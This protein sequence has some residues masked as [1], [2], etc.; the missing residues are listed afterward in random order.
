MDP[1]RVMVIGHGFSGHRFAKVIRYIENTRPELARLVAICDSN[2][3]RLRET[4]GVPC[5]AR[6]E[7]ALLE[8]EPTVAVV[9]VNESAHYDVLTYLAAGP[10]QRRLIIAEKPLTETFEQA[11]TLRSALAG[12]SVAVNFIERYSPIVQVF[13]QWWAEHAELRPTRVEFFWGKDRIRDPRPTIGV[14]SEITHPLD[15]VAYLFGLRDPRIAAVQATESDFSRFEPRCLDTVDAWIDTADFRLIGH[16]SFCWSNRLRRIFAILSDARGQG[17]IV[18]FDFDM[19]RWDC[20]RLTIRVCGEKST[21]FEY[22]V[23]NSFFPRQLDELGKVS[24]FTTR[25]IESFRSGTMHEQ[26]VGLEMAVENQRLTT[27][28]EDAIAA[29]GGARRMPMFG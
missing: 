28:I 9:A 10:S 26:Q 5:Y 13:R 19:P 20:D 29:G 16:A 27:M 2:A 17:V 23:D 3:S 22:S 18:N 24:T 7:Q 11:L 14:V 1:E 25:A 8:A 6:L 12:T 21:C 4:D 15:L